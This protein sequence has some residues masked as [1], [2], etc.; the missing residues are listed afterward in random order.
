MAESEARDWVLV[1]VEVLHRRARTFLGG[2]A[3]PDKFGNVLF[4]FAQILA[5]ICVLPTI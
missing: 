1:L 4:S 2:R 3:K 5:D